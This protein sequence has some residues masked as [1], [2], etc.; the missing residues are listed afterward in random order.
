[1]RCFGTAISRGPT[2]DFA[3]LAA[4]S[5]ALAVDV[6]QD[7]A[8]AAQERLGR[9]HFGADRQLAFG[10]TVAAVLLELGFGVVGLGAAGAERALVHL[11]AH[12]EGAR[13]RELRR[14]ERTRVEAVAAADAE[15]LVVEDDAVVGAIEA[16]DGA[17]RHAG[18]VR[19]VHARDRDR[20]LAGHAVVDGDDAPPV[21]APRNLVLLLARGHAAVALDAAFGIAEKLHSGHVFASSMPSWR[22]GRAS[23]WFPASSSPSRSRTSWRC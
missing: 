13:L 22:P 14:A 1:L 7:V 4:R 9:A 10:E 12:P 18:R 21:D 23:S 6:G 5:H 19:A 3:A 16:V 15:I 2:P 8:F 11:A 20:P 17:H